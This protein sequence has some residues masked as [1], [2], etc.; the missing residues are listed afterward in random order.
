MATAD[1][2]DRRPFLNGR[3]SSAAFQSS[4]SNAEMDTLNCNS[5]EDDDSE[6]R[7]AIQ[8]QMERDSIRRTE[9]GYLLLQQEVPQS[10]AKTVVP[11]SAKTSSAHAFII[12]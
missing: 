3:G 11:A 12:A 8:Y 7:F 5:V 10:G 9:S 1:R 4:F 2:F 6:A